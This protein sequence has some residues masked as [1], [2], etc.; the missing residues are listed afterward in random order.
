LLKRLRFESLGSRGHLLRAGSARTQAFIPCIPR[1]VSGVCRLLATVP[2]STTM[3]NRLDELKN[4]LPSLVKTFSGSAL[5][6]KTIPNATTKLLRDARNKQTNTRAHERFD[7]HEQVVEDTISWF[8]YEHVQRDDRTVVNT[9]PPPPHTHT[10]RCVRVLPSAATHN[11][12]MRAH[13]R[14]TKCCQDKTKTP[15]QRNKA[16]HGNA[17][18]TV[19]TR[20][21]A[22]ERCTHSPSASL[23]RKSP[24]SSCVAVASLPRIVVGIG[25]AGVPLEPLV[26]RPTASSSLPRFCPRADADADADADDVDDEAG[27]YLSAGDSKLTGGLSDRNRPPE[28][29]RCE[30]YASPARPPPRAGLTPIGLLEYGDALR[31]SFGDPGVDRDLIATPCAPRRSN[32]DPGFTSPLPLRGVSVHPPPP[33]PLPLRIPEALMPMPLREGDVTAPLG[34]SG[35]VEACAVS[36]STA[37]ESVVLRYE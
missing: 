33:P 23:L 1:I 26:A 10:Q 25:P 30:P 11:D 4:R 9:P 12:T 27:A 17:S 7:R 2:A 6:F 22:S 21:Q 13:V 19:G 20:P 14:A 24:M 34:T 37:A 32:P 29:G 28:C 5:H 15:Q 16:R 36:V 3:I 8:F 18:L 35:S 31:P